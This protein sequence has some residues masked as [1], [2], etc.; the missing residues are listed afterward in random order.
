M[1]NLIRAISENGKVAMAAVDS[2]NI[3][4]K[5]E[6]IHKT[7][8]VASAALG[9][10]L[11]GASLMGSYLKEEENSLTLRVNG[12]GPI[13]T[14]L[15][16][17]DSFGNV[18]GYAEHPFIE[19]PIRA[20]GKLDVG[21]AVGRDGVLSVVRDLGTGEPYIGQTALVSGEI[22]ED[23]TAYYAASEQ[24]PCVCALGVLVEKDL[25]IAAGGGY[26]L[27]L[28]PGADE[29]VIKIIENNIQKSKP[30]TELLRE[31]ASPLDI[32]ETVMDGCRPQVLLERDVEYRCRCNYERT[33]GILA[34]LGREELEQMREER[35]T[36]EVECHFCNRRYEYDIDELLRE[37]K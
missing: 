6:E 14:V 21:G 16:V 17:S 20:D 37:M 15:A 31:G 26:L 32:V 24:S 10:L 7:S 36:A 27:T 12:G 13:G 30:I 34:S 28:L 9:R 5:M 8:S 19:L 29:E 11:T 2:L 23:V 4:Q 25:H 1:S 22:A 33:K 3:L 18:R 35:T